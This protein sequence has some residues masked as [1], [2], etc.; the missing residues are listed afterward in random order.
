MLCCVCRCW[1]MFCR[2]QEWRCMFIFIWFSVLPIYLIHS[3]KLGVSRV[4]TIISSWFVH[5]FKSYFLL[6]LQRHYKWFHEEPFKSVKKG[7]LLKTLQIVL[8]RG[9]C[10]CNTSI[11]IQHICDTKLIWEVLI[12]LGLHVCVLLKLYYV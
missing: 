12:R 8:R 5:L 7:I 2:N 10:I 3:I 6:F 1:C 4:L 9:K 11:L